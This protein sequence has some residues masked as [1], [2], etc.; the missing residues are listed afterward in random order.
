MMRESNLL[1]KFLQFYF[2]CGDFHQKSSQNEVRA[3]GSAN[4][5]LA[6]DFYQMHKTFCAQSG[7]CKFLVHLCKI[8]EKII[9]KHH[10]TYI[11]NQKTSDIYFILA[12]NS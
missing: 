9:F 6:S 11:L 12:F 7:L 8:A 5:N 1:S 4:I 2:F 10:D 3:K